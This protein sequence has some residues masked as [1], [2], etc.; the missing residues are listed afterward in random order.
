MYADI[1]ACMDGRMM[2]NGWGYT[3]DTG[4][5]Q[6]AALV[7]VRNCCGMF[8]ELPRLSRRCM[9]GLQLGVLLAVHGRRNDLKNRVEIRPVI[10]APAGTG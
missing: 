5:W 10:F 2:T 4:A 8:Q 6:E 1:H 7:P 3:T 9:S